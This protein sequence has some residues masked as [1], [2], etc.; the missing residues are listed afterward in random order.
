MTDF[1]ERLKRARIVQVLVFYL[2]ASW[3][4][5]QVV[6]VLQESLALPDWIAPV[7]VILLMI[8]LVIIASTAMI[9]SSAAATT[10]GTSAFSVDGGD[11]DRLGETPIPEAAVSL[12]TWKRAIGG[13]VL[14]FSG[15]FIVAAIAVNM[16]G[17]DSLGTS[18][19]SAD[20][21][22]AGIAVLPFTVTGPDM[23]VWSEGMVDLL[24]DNLDGTGGLRAIDPRTV[25]SH[26][27]RRVGEEGSPDLN[28]MLTVAGATGARYA[29]VGGAVSIGGTVR[30]SADVYDLASGEPMGT[31][32]AEGDAEDVMN[33]VD[34]LSVETAGVALATGGG[35]LN[36]RHRTSLSTQSPVA[37]RAYLEGEALYREA[38]FA[39]AAD[40]FRRAVTADST[41]ALANLR[42][43]RSI[44]W[45]RNIGDDEARE[46]LE[47]ANR[48]RDRMPPREIELLDVEEMLELQVPRVVSAATETARNYPDDAEA[49]ELLGE[50]Y[51]H[52]GAEALVSQRE[53]LEPFDRAIALDPTFSPI[54]F[55]PIEMAT[56][57]G[58]SERAYGY[59]EALEEH[60]FGDGRAAR[61]D[62]FLDLQFGDSSTREEAL[63]RVQ[64]DVPDREIITGWMYGFRRTA[65]SA[66]ADR[67]M[68]GE[69]R[70]RGSAE[71][72]VGIEVSVLLT[73]GLVEEALEEI[74][75]AP[76]A[77]QPNVRRAALLQ[78]SAWGGAPDDPRVRSLIASED[79][80][81]IVGCFS[82]AILA[83]DLGD[84]AMHREA[85]AAHRAAVEGRLAAL[86][87]LPDAEAEGQRR[88][89]QQEALWPDV[90]EAYGSWRRGDVTQVPRAFERARAVQPY[91]NWLFNMRSQALR[92]WMAELLLAEGQAEQAA[93]HYDSLW[94]APVGGWYTFRL[95]GLGD[96][97]RTL[98]RDAEARDHYQEFLD[99]WEAAPDDHPLVQR[100][101]DGL[102][103]LG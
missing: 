20:E 39:G 96:A 29:V 102:A 10:S 38:D 64:S 58:D 36:L 32:A 6:D 22:G 31:G 37:L 95:V 94:G 76:W 103:A 78:W 93:R 88:H 33:L 46:A 51:A 50:S 89:W 48:F 99:A 11:P 18:E 86:D 23:E 80:D 30:L 62:I 65:R 28:E 26:W 66:P 16:G 2:G 63:Q 91:A 25:M 27:N 13:G 98:G 14:A 72:A 53:A 67:M 68:A 7:A 82:S 21:A 87:S 77:D 45:L 52:Q 60:S 75:S 19:I 74:F 69:L 42:L 97:M 17:G 57:L 43:S 81:A 47:R 49:W 44:G 12:F 92:W 71:A 59:L 1:L 101:R 34:R 40:A 85:V 73:T 55:H 61:Y 4:I 5:L 56:A 90:A 24:A 41:F 83:A 84:W 3:V 79:C 100:A 35:A 70:R 8:G 9:Q 15:L 54:Y